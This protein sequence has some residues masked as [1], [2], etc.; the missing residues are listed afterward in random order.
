MIPHL[1]QLFN[2]L[3]IEEKHRLLLKR[4]DALCG[5]HIEFP[6]SESPLFIPRPLMEE[7]E[8][9]GQDIVNQLM[10]NP[11]YLTASEHAIPYEYY[12]PNESPH[13]LFIAVDFGLTQNER[14]EIVPRLIELQGFPTLFAYQPVLSQQYKEVYGLPREL[15]SLLGGLDLEAYYDLLRKSVLGFEAPENVVLMEIDPEKQKTLPDF[16]LTERLCGI[17][18]VNIREITKEGNRLYYKRNGMLTPIYRVFN[19]AIADELMRS[20]AK[21][22]FSFR[23]D[24]HIEWAGHPNWFFRISKFSIPFLRH[25]TVPRTHFLSDLK[26]FPDDLHN[27]VLKPLYSFA[28]TGVKVGP[29]KADLDAIP[30]E[31]RNRYLLQEKI[32]YAGVVETPHGPTKAEVRLMF[33]W[34]DHP[35]PVNNLVR[36]GRGKM[37]GVDHNKNLRW[38]G[39]SAGLYP[40][41]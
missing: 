31:E 32:E 15:K 1:R 9:A 29:T 23:D 16:I 40:A 28:G 6:V 41:Q 26:T 33:I 17:Q 13:P 5:T 14:G 24:L 12:V 2:S 4:L 34:L 8:S 18:T 22:P 38:V 39:S 21:L 11:A 25:P 30:E 37:M 10:S 7:M 27:W 36:M 19:R 20:E 3:F 35:L